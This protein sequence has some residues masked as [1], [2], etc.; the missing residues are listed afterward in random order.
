MRAEHSYFSTVT[1]LIDVIIYLSARRRHIPSLS[2]ALGVSERTVY[3]YVSLIRD[4]GFEV[5]FQRDAGYK[6]VKWPENLR[7]C[8]AENKN[9]LF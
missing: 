2:A 1:K 8:V 9:N 3:R 7:K 4:V 6:I 5:D